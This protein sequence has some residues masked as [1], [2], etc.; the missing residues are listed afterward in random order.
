MPTPM[1]KTRMRTQTEEMSALLDNDRIV[2]IVMI[3]GFAVA[4][5]YTPRSNDYSREVIYNS[6]LN[7]SHEERMAQLLYDSR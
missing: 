7:M 4:L 3:R 6:C 1:S 2:T 5:N